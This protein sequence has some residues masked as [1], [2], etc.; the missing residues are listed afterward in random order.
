MMEAAAPAACWDRP[1]SSHMML[2]AAHSPARRPPVAHS[3]L[4]ST[5]RGRGRDRAPDRGPT[6]RERGSR[7][8]TKMPLTSCIRSRSATSWTTRWSTSSPR[9]PANRRSSSRSIRPLSMSFRPAMPAATPRISQRR[10]SR[11]SRSTRRGL[12]RAYVQPDVPEPVGDGSWNKYTV[13]WRFIM[14]V[15]SALGDAKLVSIEPTWPKDP[16]PAGRQSREPRRPAR[17]GFGPRPRRR[18]IVSCPPAPAEAVR[19]GAGL[20]YARVSA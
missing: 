14:R 8:P 18:G 3:P 5:M 17:P 6:D 15:N 4:S 1:S 2:A 13:H 7:K 16:R 20:L 11:P 12:M 10:P 9:P 19:L